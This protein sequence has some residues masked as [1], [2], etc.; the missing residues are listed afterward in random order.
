MRR[1]AH[2]EARQSELRARETWEKEHNADVYIA[3]DYAGMKSGNLHFYFGYE[4]IVCAYHENEEECDRRD[5]DEKEWAFVVSRAEKEILV[6]PQ[7]KLHP[8]KNEDTS[9]Y[10]LSGI[11]LFL[12]ETPHSESTP[13]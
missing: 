7:S 3:S 13:N 8:R 12:K 9:F 2:E 11:A 1:E 5:C 6:I 4:H 10:L